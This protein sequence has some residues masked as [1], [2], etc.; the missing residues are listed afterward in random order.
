MTIYT[1]KI[2]ACITMILDHIK[3]GIPELN[4]FITVYFGRLAYPLFAFFI[5]EGYIHTSDLK[6]YYKRLIIFG[7]IS[8]IPFMLFRTL[9]GEYLLLNIMFTLILGL[10]SINIYDKIKNKFISI[11]LVIITIYLGKLLN[12]DYNW[13]GVATVFLLYLFKDYKVLKVLSFSIL[14]LLYYYIRGIL[15]FTSSYIILTFLFT[16]S[17]TFIICLYNGEK[18]KGTSKFFYWFYPIHMIVIYLISF[19]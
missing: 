3:Y 7:I 1:L 9:V 10:I 14:T 4:N 18:G 15:D 6:K 19:V 16:I 17:S 8:Q 2:I 13:Y 5:V 11:P 12:V